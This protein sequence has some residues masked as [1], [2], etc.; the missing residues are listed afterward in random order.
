MISEPYESK[1]IISR[2]ISLSLILWILNN[3]SKVVAEGSSVIYGERSMFKVQTITP[4]LDQDEMNF[5]GI[6]VSLFL[7][8]KWGLGE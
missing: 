2:L 6:Y 3:Q 7:S 4:I 5:Q 1:I 8:Y